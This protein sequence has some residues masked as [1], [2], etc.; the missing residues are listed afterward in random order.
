MVRTRVGSGPRLAL[1]K[2]WYSLSQNPETL[3]RVARTP[4][5]EVQDPSQGSGL[6]PRRSWTLPEG[7]VRICRG[8]TLSH[9]GPDPSLIP[10]RILSSL[11]TWRP[12]IRPRG[13]VGCCSPRD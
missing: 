11:A 7:P 9:G 6:Y 4:H 2:A 8:P 10:W 12:W 13:G 3:L 1:I 5:R